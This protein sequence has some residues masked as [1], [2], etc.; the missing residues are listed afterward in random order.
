MA[1]AE[2]KLI[3]IDVGAPES[4]AALEAAIQTAIGQT[5]DMGW[6]GL[7]DCLDVY[8][9]PVTISIVGLKQL[10]ARSPYRAR[11][12]EI[13][14]REVAERRSEQGFVINVD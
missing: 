1:G 2:P 3:R 9:V 5:Y 13:A 14:F 10:R 7:V 11:L 4:Y 8:P 12:L 6:Y